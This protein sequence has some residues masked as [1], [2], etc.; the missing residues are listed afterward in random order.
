MINGWY[1]LVDWPP[2]AIFP[3]RAPPADRIGFIRER[4]AEIGEREL[5]AL[6]APEKRDQVLSSYEDLANQ[7]FVPAMFRLGYLAYHWNDI[8]RGLFWLT[9]AAEFEH[10]FA[11]E[12]LQQAKVL[13]SM[14]NSSFASAYKTYTSP[15]PQLPGSASP[16][17]RSLKEERAI[18]LRFSGSYHELESASEQ[19]LYAW[20]VEHGFIEHNGRETARDIY[21]KCAESG[22]PPAYVALGRMELV[23]A[24]PDLV[25]AKQHLYRAL[26]LYAKQGTASPQQCL[27]W[28][29]YMHW[30]AG[31]KPLGASFLEVCARSG[32]R[33][34]RYMM[35]RTH[36]SDSIDYTDNKA[37]AWLALAAF[38]GHPAALRHL[39]SRSGYMERDEKFHS[40]LRPAETKTAFYGMLPLLFSSLSV[41]LNCV[42]NLLLSFCL[43]GHRVSP[44]GSVYMYV[45]VYVYVCVNTPTVCG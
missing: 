39:T 41:R 16:A 24:K 6:H 12:L 27:F 26:L 44:F 7:F 14:R 1:I 43:F 25:A 9:A 29:G 19:Y 5:L 4:Y 42:I 35:S 2:S 21:V 15:L 22:Y 40:I 3:P 34:A 8:V 11:I 10:P 30:H 45:C 23:S 36:H 32:M 33:E 38:S 20:L 28:L 17:D 13:A 18:L 31:D 37:V